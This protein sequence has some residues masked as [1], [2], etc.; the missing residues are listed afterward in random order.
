MGEKAFFCNPGCKDSF[1]NDRICGLCYGLHKFNGIVCLHREEFSLAAQVCAY[2][3]TPVKD[4]RPRYI[5]AKFQ[6]VP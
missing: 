2:C 5:L 1:Y 3:N 4:K 6:V